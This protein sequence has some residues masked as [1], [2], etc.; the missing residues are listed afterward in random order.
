V[1]NYTGD[2][3]GTFSATPQRNIYRA[4][5][6][7]V[8]FGLGYQWKPAVSFFLDLTNAFNEPQRTYIG[9]ESRVQRVIYTGQAVVFGV[10]GRF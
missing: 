3:L 8:N 10:N 7:I 4:E 5:R 1:L 2:Y 6:T 9:Y